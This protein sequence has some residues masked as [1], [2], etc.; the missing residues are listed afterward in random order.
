M[1][2]S[3]K[4]ELPAHAVKLEDAV[5]KAAQEIIDAVIESCDNSGT[6]YDKRMVLSR[7][8]ALNVNYRLAQIVDKIHWPTGVLPSE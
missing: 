2:D 6:I 3:I 7:I 1:K 8:K 5:D 4:K